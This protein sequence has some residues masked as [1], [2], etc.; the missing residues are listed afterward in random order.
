MYV[1]VE[2][3]VASAYTIKQLR[4]DNPSI[5]FPEKISEDMLA[6]YGVFEVAESAPPPINDNQTAM[7]DGFSFT[8]GRWC[9]T[10]RVVD[11]HPREIASRRVATLRRLLDESDY[12]FAED[13]DQKN[14]PEWEQLK[15][16][17]QSWREEI[18]GHERTLSM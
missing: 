8:N 16:D 15:L 18:R 7:F 11:T 14:T 5:S 1:K 12:K 13:Y 10:W 9:T 6:D 17:R 3:G 4:R 2:G